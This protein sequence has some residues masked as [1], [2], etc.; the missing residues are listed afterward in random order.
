MG[1]G[2]V[3]PD[4]EPIDLQTW[5]SLNGDLRGKIL[6]NDKVGDLVVRTVWTG[7]VEPAVDVRPFGTILMRGGYFLRE[8]RQYNTPEEAEAGHNDVVADARRAA[9]RVV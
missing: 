4:G 3:N 9:L 5:S 7:I 8:V 2:F 6:A 1:G